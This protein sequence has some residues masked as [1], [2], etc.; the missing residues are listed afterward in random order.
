MIKNIAS[1]THNIF[2]Y[3]FTICLTYSKSVYSKKKY[4][5]IYITI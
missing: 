2:I 4:N 1:H 3:P 5:I